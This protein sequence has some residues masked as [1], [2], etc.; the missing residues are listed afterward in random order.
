MT[1]EVLTIKEIEYEEYFNK[2]L[3]EKWAEEIPIF[4]NNPL[5]P[6]WRETHVV[7]LSLMNY[8]FGEVII[9][10]EADKKSNPTGTIKD[11]AA[12]EI[13]ALYRDF[14]RI[15]LLNKKIEKIKIPRISIITAGNAGLSL[16][17]RMEKHGLPP[18]KLLLDKKIDITKLKG[19]Y[20]DIYL[21]DLNRELTTHDIKKLTKNENGIDITSNIIFRPQEVYYDWHVHEVFNL[22]PD[23]IFIPYGS[24]RLYENY[25]TWQEKSIRNIIEGI[26]D[27]RLKI[28][29][30]DLIKIS[31]VGAKPRKIKTSKANKLTRAYLP[32]RIFEEE[33]ILILNKLKFTGKV[34]GIYYVEEE[35]IEVAHK[36]IN[37]YC[38]SEYSASTGLA[39]YMKMYNKWK[40]TQN[41]KVI[42]INTGKGIQL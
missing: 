42:V 26:K 5:N 29:I 35:K 12:W 30:E 32:F 1:I 7:K 11:R 37:K 9:K 2:K 25:I 40:I 8:G 28:G 19:Q 15:I 6:E 17:N 23:F 34:T 22:R 14:A 33:D 3:A 16:V 4:S 10:N 18:I 31:I 38:E 36:L 39:L 24:G 27:P 21:T 13:A 20:A 41:K